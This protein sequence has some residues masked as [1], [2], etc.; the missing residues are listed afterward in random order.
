MTT[1]ALIG[2]GACIVPRKRLLIVEDECIVAF[3]LT[4][5]LED[6]GYAVVATAASSDEALRA[7]DA[8]CPDLV[9]MDI[10]IAGPM[11]GIQAGC[12]LRNRHGI[13]LV[14]LTA[15][16]DVTTLSR[17]LATEPDGYLVKPYNEHSLRTTIEVAF[18]KHEAERVARIAHERE[19]A[20]LEQKYSDMTTLA[21]RLRR[22]ATRDPLTGLCNRRRLEDIAKREVCFGQR[23]SHPV[24]FILLD[25]D[26]FKQMNDTFGHA[27]G[28]AV[29][30]AV[31]DFLRSRLRVYDVACRYGGEEIVIVVPGE[32][33]VGTAALAEHLRTGIE[34]LDVEL[35]GVQLPRFTAS[36]GVAAFTEHGGELDSLLSAADKALYRAKTEGRNR[37][38]TATAA[39]GPNGSRDS[40]DGERN[41]RAADRLARTTTG[42]VM[43]M[44]ELDASDDATGDAGEKPRFD[45]S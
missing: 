11:D 15:N 40:A 39:A 34:A 38:I 45:P 33:S 26:R 35:A 18:C 32:T 7:A 8:E 23:D 10:N 13:P 20:Q 37:V 25:L 43:L 12:L 1:S 21:R 29:L 2:P 17:A 14:Y 22:E 24:G 4:V 36:F 44:R 5:T 41:G 3:D 31:A 27:A 42:E 16:V 30:L 28:D 19:R 9:L 6:M